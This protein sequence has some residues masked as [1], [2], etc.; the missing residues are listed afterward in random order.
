[1]TA[2]SVVV[3]TRDRSATL[4][5]TLRAVL[6]QLAEVDGEVV[7]VDDGSTDDTPELVEGL[8]A[9]DPRIRLL[10]QEPRGP[11]AARNLGIG[12]ARG[13]R[14]LLLG[15]DTRPDVGCLRA[16]GVGSEHGLQG[17]IDWDPEREITPLMEFLAPSGP[18][19]YF[20]GLE[21]DR[22]VPW[23]AV[24]GSNLSAPRSW[25]REDPFDEGFPFAAV[26]DTELAYRW[27]KK[28]RRVVWKPDA[29]CWH[30][31]RYDRLEP[32]LQRQVR[33]GHSARAAVLRHPPMVGRL[34]LQPKL[35]G[36]VVLARLLGRCVLGRP[37]GNE[38]WDLRCRWAFLRGF[39]GLSRPAA[40]RR[41][42]VG[43]VRS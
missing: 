33:A 39:S 7:V 35:F 3:P 12:A 9:H 5:R 11:A 16:H 10:R 8:A 21:E 28:D 22:P 20:D 23:T 30:E 40:G 24:L 37:V 6:E 15:D 29:R 31:H 17:R 4:T 34:V 36:W 14:V 41:P 19:F 43:V 18:Q 13:E 27:Q 32:F 26:E 42:S 1:M 2:L 25:F 38:V